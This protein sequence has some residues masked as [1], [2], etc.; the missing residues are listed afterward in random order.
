MGKPNQTASK[1]MRI[2]WW[3]IL[4]FILWSVS[5]VVTYRF[6]NPPFTYLMFKRTYQQ[7]A[8]GKPA[9]IERQ[10][11]PLEEISPYLVRAVIAAEDNNFPHH[12]GFDL[13][14]MKNALE[15]NQK[16][17]RLHGA[18]TITQQTAKNV[19][20]WPRR[21]YVRKAFEFYFTF[22]IEVFWSKKR[23]MEIY[24]NVIETGPGIYGAEAAARKYFHKPASRLTAGEAAL[25]SAAL[26]APRK[27][28]PGNPS[29]YMLRRQA[30]IL[31]IMEKL[32]P[33]YLK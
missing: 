9:H 23:I 26:P 11:K 31:D 7:V 15:H 18:S 8:G 10:W 1:I 28:N 33:V 3:G 17:S 24:L 32:G 13:E 4:V 5:G 14:A 29:A 12:F 27:R 19:F 20:L 22:L 2:V 6:I 21:S 16:S 25:I 30:Q